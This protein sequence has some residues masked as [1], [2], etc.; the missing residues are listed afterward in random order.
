M[1][2]S[3]ISTTAIISHKAVLGKDVKIG[4]Y[5]IIGDNVQIGDGCIIMH[6]TIIDQN[7]RI[8]KE[9]KIFPF[10]SIGT[11]PQDITFKGEDTFIEIGDNNII[12]EFTSINRGTQKGGRLTSIGNNNYLMVYTHIAHDCKIGNNI[13]FINGATLAGHVEV[14]DSAVV[15][16]FSSVSQFVRIGRNA[17][18]G[19]YSIVLQDILPFAKVSQSRDYY[20]FYGPNSIGMMRNGI[21]R[22]FINRIK[23]VF[24]IIFKSGLNTT[25]A[26]DKLKKDFKNSEEAKIVI[27]FIT[28]TKRGIFKNF[29]FNV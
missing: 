6:H 23:E 1:N 28:K 10:C 8:G 29:K 12:R 27:D 2:S 21:D 7:T 14:E 9:C 22:E 20:N 19:G 13:I 17:Y 24:N 5:S 3:D 18:I 4:A 25:Q 26:I 16:A 15:G 11:E